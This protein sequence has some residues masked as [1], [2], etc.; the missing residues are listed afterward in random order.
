MFAAERNSLA[1]LV[2]AYEEAEWLKNQLKWMK[3]QVNDLKVSKVTENQK[4]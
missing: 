2:Q 3:N 4:Y 1:P